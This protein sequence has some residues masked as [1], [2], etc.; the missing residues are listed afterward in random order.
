MHP[1]KNPNDPLANERFQQVGAAY[2]I[3]SDESLRSKYDRMG[4]DG[5]G[6]VPMM[7]SLMIFNFL[8]GSEK[9]EPIVGEMYLAM[10]LGTCYH[11]NI[12]KQA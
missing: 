12:V 5:V 3:L 7:D 10:Q 11:E 4:K 2:Q 9:F 1:D 6:D 8:F